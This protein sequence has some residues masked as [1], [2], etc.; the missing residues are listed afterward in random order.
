M[1]GGG[2]LDG[3]RGGDGGDLGGGGLGLGGGG[4][5]GGGG[6]GF[7]GGDAFGAT[8]P[9]LSTKSS[10]HKS[11]LSIARG[12]MHCVWHVSNCLCSGSARRHTFTDTLQPRERPAERTKSAPKQDWRG[13]GPSTS[14][15]AQLATAHSGR[16]A[17]APPARHR[18]PTRP[19]LPVQR[20]TLRGKP[21]A[22]RKRELGGARAQRSPTA[23]T[24]PAVPR[25]TWTLV[26][27][28]GA[29]GE[30]EQS[31]SVLLAVQKRAGASWLC[32]STQGAA[33]ARNRPLAGSKRAA[34]RRGGR[35]VA[36]WAAGWRRRWSH[37]AEPRWARR[38]RRTCEAA[39]RARREQGRGWVRTLLGRGGDRRA[40]NEESNTIR[41]RRRAQVSVGAGSAA[42]LRARVRVSTRH[43]SEVWVLC[44]W[45]RPRRRVGER[46]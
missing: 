36:R 43:N 7:G 45:T 17:G 10:A 24:R 19:Y 46:L 37:K 32:A 29:E 20:A 34:A 16:S 31:A 5:L 39:V 38:W 22:S 3:G 41:T 18:L 26:N 23:R 6:L 44:G 14:P 4:D 33:P 1:G 40:E 13:A 9:A 8:A 2:G 15:P 28:H 35:A 21:Q 27:L 25:R 12:A 11:T 30:L 42:E